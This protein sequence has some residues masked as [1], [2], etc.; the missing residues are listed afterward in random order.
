M[1]IP[2]FIAWDK[3]DLKIKKVQSIDYEDERVIFVS[4][5]YEADC[6]HFNDCDLLQFTG[7]HDKNGKEIYENF[8][9]NGAC[10]NGSYAYGKVV[11]WKDGFFIEP[12]GKFVEGMAY[13]YDSLSH[14]EV[15]GNIYENPEK[16]K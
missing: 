14:I 2:K 1:R 5:P 9:V 10:F 4:E 7:L 15:I 11:Y 12:I 16:L 13:L 3:I 8:L 6:R